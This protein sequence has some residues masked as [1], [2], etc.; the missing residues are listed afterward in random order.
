VLTLDLLQYAARGLSPESAAT[1]A[2]ELSNASAVE[3]QWAL[4]AGLGPLAYQAV[5]STGDRVPLDRQAMLLGADLAARVLQGSRVEAAAEVIDLCGSLG[6][7]VTPLK[8]I[9]ISEQHYPSAH[10]RPMSDIDFLAPGRPYAEIEA[11]FLQRGYELSSIDMGVD[12]AHGKPLFDRRRNVWV[13]IHT[14][15][16]PPASPLQSHPVFAHPA[17]PVVAADSDFHGRKVLRLRDEAQL[18]YIAAYWS[19]DLSTQSIHPTFV[20]PVLDATIL[21]RASATTLDWAQLDRWL[22]DDQA[23][24]SLYLLLSCLS[25][26]ELASPPPGFLAM[27]A[28][29]QSIIGRTENRIIQSLIDRYLLGGRPLR[30]IHSW[31]VWLNLLGPGARHAKSMLLPWRIAF[32]PSYPH[33]FDVGAQARRLARLFRRSLRSADPPT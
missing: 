29:R 16:F 7:R 27:L 32:P 5:R 18:F 30:L 15:L 11:A 2:D 25:R 4:E 17:D 19:R 20:T 12:P 21:L 14:S 8:G 33:R 28:A 22:G 13:E 3:L 31:H 10:L 9:S 24:A 6:L 26:H 1:V 23:T